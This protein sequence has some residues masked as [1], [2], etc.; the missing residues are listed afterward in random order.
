MLTYYGYCNKESNIYKLKKNS[1]LV[2]SRETEQT[3]CTHACVYVFMCIYY[4]E[5][6]PLIIQAAKVLSLSLSFLKTRRVDV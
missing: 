5:L 2:F 4:K 3:G 1:V 6:D